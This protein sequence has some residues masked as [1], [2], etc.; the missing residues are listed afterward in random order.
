MKQTDYT[1][2]Y[3]T[4]LSFYEYNDCYA[5]QYITVQN[6]A[7]WFLT[8]YMMYDHCKVVTTRLVGEQDFA[9]I[10]SHYKM[11]AIWNN[12]RTHS[13]VKHVNMLEYE[14]LDND[15]ASVTEV[16][17]FVLMRLIFNTKP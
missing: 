9:I 16:L 17:D 15:L 5:K 12:K 4:A 7:L 6:L 8:I 10:V 11:S 2:V 3:E 14:D 13:W 1:T